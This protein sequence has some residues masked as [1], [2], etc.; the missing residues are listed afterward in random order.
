M[1]HLIK[2]FIT[3]NLLLYSIQ[4]YS[5]KSHSLQ[6][7]TSALLTTLYK[8]IELSMKRN[9]IIKIWKKLENNIKQLQ[10]TG[11]TASLIRNEIYKTIIEYSS[12]SLTLS[13]IDID[14]TLKFKSFF[15]KNEKKLSPLAHVIC[16]MVIEELKQE[17]K[18][19]TKILFYKNWIRNLQKKNI[20]EVNIYFDQVL[21]DI[22]NNINNRLL[23]FQIKLP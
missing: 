6:D 17:T 19:N 16:S 18:M 21:I 10:N 8:T 7:E 15:K 9:E 12:S 1:I 23:L 13:S 2:I 4:S 3:I 20:S 5:K 22:I 14:T 11:H